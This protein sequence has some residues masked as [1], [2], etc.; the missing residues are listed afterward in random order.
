MVRAGSRNK[1]RKI[2]IKILDKIKSKLSG[3]IGP[4]I[5]LLFF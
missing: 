3:I 2:Y 4:I 1:I 5:A